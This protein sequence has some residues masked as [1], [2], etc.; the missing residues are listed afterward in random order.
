[1]SE[2]TIL[3]FPELSPNVS[4]LNYYNLRRNWSRKVAPHLSDE[5]LNE[6]MVR[7]FNRYTMGRWARPFTTGML[8]EDVES[9]Y[10]REEHRGPYPRFWRY[11]KHGA[12]H[13]I[14]N[15][16]LRLAQLTE[17]TKAWR[18]V[19]SNRHSTVWC[20]KDT[21]FEFNYQALGVPSNECWENARNGGGGKTLEPGEE[22]LCRL[23]E[24]YFVHYREQR[25]AIVVH[26][27]RKYLDQF[28]AN[29]HT[30][31]I[32]QASQRRILIE[33]LLS[34]QNLERVA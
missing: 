34:L 7:D 24:P 2:Q 10:W 31:E 14:V 9:C 12:C 26:E 20:G 33:H 32:C 11:V 25:L 29:Q 19:T 21:L 4:Q 16:A 8:P 13:W 30:L 22:A 6:I 15:F 17:P 28:I 18:I 5:R 27:M 1:M 23:A 3:F